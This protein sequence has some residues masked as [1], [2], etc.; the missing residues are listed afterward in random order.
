MKLMELKIRSYKFYTGS[1]REK[2]NFAICNIGRIMIASKLLLIWTAPI[3]NTP[4]V[5][6]QSL[7]M[8]HIC[9]YI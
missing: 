6:A 8:Y 9:L 1:N 7:Y 2:S 3:L 5:Y 4:T